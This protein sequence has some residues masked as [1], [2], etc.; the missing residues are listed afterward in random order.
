MKAWGITSYQLAQLEGP[1]TFEFE[2]IREIGRAIAFKANPTSSRSRYA[3]RAAS[4]RRLKALCYH[5]WRDLVLKLFEMGATRVQSTMGDWRTPDEFRWQ[6][7]DLYSVNAGSMMQ[8]RAFGQL[9]EH[10]GI[11]AYWDSVDGWQPEWGGHTITFSSMELVNG[12]LVETSRRLIKQTDIQRCPFVIMVPEHYREDGSCKCNDP[13]E[14]ERM[15]LEWE[16]TDQDFR[17][18]GLIS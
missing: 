11:T 2:N 8:P 17:E 9:C 16:Y 10:G 6:L 18:A 12:E 3:R 14:R 13:A 15:K 5:G 4:G 1:E 7:P